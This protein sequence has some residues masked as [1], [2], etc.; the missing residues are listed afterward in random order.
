M[1]GKKKQGTK[2][3]NPQGSKLQGTEE[4]GL[5]GLWVLLNQATDLPWPGDQEGPF[6]EASST[7]TKPLGM[8][9]R[10][11]SGNNAQGGRASGMPRSGEI[12]RHSPH[13]IFDGAGETL[14]PQRHHASYNKAEV[15]EELIHHDA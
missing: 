12:L 2:T 4:K 10:I 7:T 8:Y 9:G 11:H 6:N 15:D 1:S 3:P 14:E 5:L 13:F